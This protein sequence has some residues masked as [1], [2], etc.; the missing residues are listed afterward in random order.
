MPLTSALT[1][2]FLV[3][4]YVHVYSGRPPY[5]EV[6]NWDMLPYLKEGRR[7]L[8]PDSCPDFLYE[9]MQ[10][11]WAEEPDLRPTFSQLVQEIEE[12]T[13]IMEAR[14]AAR[15]IGIHVT[16]VNVPRGNYY[17]SSDVS[18]DRQASGTRISDG[19]LAGGESGFS[20]SSHRSTV[21]RRPAVVPVHVDDADDRERARL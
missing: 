10:R 18:D 19:S 6:G 9:I 16:Y 20:S 7:L 11:C 14:S 12:R 13:S 1:L 3:L 2:F 17:N 8:Q 4:S 5:P 21:P 15:K